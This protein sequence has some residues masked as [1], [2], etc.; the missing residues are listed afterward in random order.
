[1]PA[2]AHYTTGVPWARH[3]RTGRLAL[4]GGGVPDGVGRC[5]GTGWRPGGY[6]GGV[7]AGVRS[8]ALAL[9]LLLAL[10]GAACGDAGETGSATRV[11]NQPTTV[12]FSPTRVP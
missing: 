7:R 12:P 2:C 4:A 9:A 6:S 1:V 8:L 5:G 3:R 11:P 10:L